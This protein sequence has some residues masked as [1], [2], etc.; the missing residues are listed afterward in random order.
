MSFIIKIEDWGYYGGPNEKYWDMFNITSKDSAR[1][2]T[3][4]AAQKTINWLEEAGYDVKIE[5]CEPKACPLCGGKSFA[6]RRHTDK[7]F[8]KCVKCGCGSGTYNSEQEALW[9]W[10]RRIRGSV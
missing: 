10:N 7:W 5:K 9:A 1:I 2:L 8:V 3:A 6:H 4:E